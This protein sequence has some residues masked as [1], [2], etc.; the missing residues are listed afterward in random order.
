MAEWDA[1][2]DQ[3]LGEQALNLSAA[4]WDQDGDDVISKE[5]FEQAAAESDLQLFCEG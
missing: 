4:E 3:R 1:A 2:V 5:E